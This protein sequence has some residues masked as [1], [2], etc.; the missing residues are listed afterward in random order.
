MIGGSLGVGTEIRVNF[1]GKQ[2][3]RSFQMKVL[4]FTGTLT[5]QY[6]DHISLS[7]SA[8]LEFRRLAST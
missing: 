8:L 5:F 1:T 6:T 3:W 4:I 7:M 2:S